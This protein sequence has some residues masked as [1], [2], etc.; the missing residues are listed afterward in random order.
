MSPSD[1]YIGA[2]RVLEEAYRILRSNVMVAVSDLERPSIII[3]SANAGEGKTSTCVNLARSMAHAGR[4]VVVVDLDLRKPDIH[5]QLGAHNEIGVSDA[6]LRRHA[7][8]DCL[9]YIE[10]GWGPGQT[11]TG[12]YVMPSGPHVENPAEL[13]GAGRTVQLL[14]ALTAQADA[15]LIDTPPV[16]PVA[17]TLTLGRMVAGAILVVETHRTPITAVASAKAALIR[18]QTRL[19]GVV[20][21]RFK[22]RS[23]ADRAQYAGVGYGYGYGYGE[24]PEGE[25][26]RPS[27]ESW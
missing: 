23:A 17:D 9:Q 7:V 27:D 6:L 21:N 16:L 20:L 14:E 10:T 12:L 5:R 8:N 13:L 2:E 25:P 4:R 15:V 24:R 22:P 3:T 11:P 19:L 18:N 1:N 26:A